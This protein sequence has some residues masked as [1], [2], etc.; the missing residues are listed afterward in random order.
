MEKKE[1]KIFDESLLI[2]RDFHLTNL[3][4]IN[5]TNNYS[6]YVLLTDYLSGYGV[7]ACGGTTICDLDKTHTKHKVISCILDNDIPVENIGI[8]LQFY[9]YKD[10]LVNVCLSRND[11]REFAFW[12][13]TNDESCELE[14]LIYGTI[15]W[16]K[17]Y[18]D[19]KAMMEDI[20]TYES[21]DELIK[22]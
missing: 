22:I 9:G 21:I 12:F 17:K 7:Y 3:N 1:L 6:A 4:K 11:E 19:F 20:R 18:P 10:A 15:K 2:N 5:S 13:N 14:K 16:S 8:I